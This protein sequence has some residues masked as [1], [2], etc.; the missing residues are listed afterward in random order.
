MQILLKNSVIKSL[1]SFLILAVC[2]ILTIASFSQKKITDSSNLIIQGLNIK[3]RESNEVVSTLEKRLNQASETISN[4]NSII[5]SFGTIYMVLTIVFAL[6]GLLVPIVT[7][8]FGIKPS[9]E[10]IKNLE[11]NFDSRLGEYLKTTK[12]KE[13]DTAIERV[14]NNS[15]EL[16]QNAIT[17]LSLTQH[18]GLTDIQ[19]FKLFKILETDQIDSTQKYTLA[20]VLTNKKNDFATEYCK[21][22][23]R[24]NN[25]YN[26]IIPIRYFA[27]IGVKEFIPDLVAY[28]QKVPE[29]KDSFIRIISHMKIVSLDAVVELF[30]SDKII[31][32]FNN[33]EDL[34]Y[35]R[36]HRLTNSFEQGYEEGQI[37]ETQ[38]YKLVFDK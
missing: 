23:L 17:F 33:A 32:L 9:R 18:E 4:E 36:N 21:K 1:K 16:R 6:I 11:A 22:V 15:I 5:T 31:A 3:I 29:K 35:F 26:E 10:Q 27:M 20:Y 19:Y 2:L 37:K 34:K 38:L 8:Y 14:T 12:E 7:Y 28:L 25:L 24:T 30:N 13:I